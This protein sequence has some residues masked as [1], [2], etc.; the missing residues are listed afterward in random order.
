ML[1]KMTMGILGLAVAAATVL[2]TTA[3]AQTPQRTCRPAPVVV[4]ATNAA[5]TATGLTAE[6]VTTTLQGGATLAELAGSPEEIA[7]LQ[8][9]I[10]QQALIR[11]DE[12]VAKG[13][14]TA[15]RAAHLKQRL[16]KAVERLVT[17]GGGPYWGEGRGGLFWGNWRT[18][19]AAY[20]DMTTS[21]L[22]AALA[23]GESLA[24]LATAQGKSVEG[25][26]E[27]LSAKAATRLQ[28]AVAEG[29]ITQE[30]ADR[31]LARLTTVLTRMVQGEGPCSGPERRLLPLGRRLG[32][33]T[34]GNADAIL[35]LLLGE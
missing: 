28:T 12:A 3:Y 13:V 30:E 32:N 2:P 25:L 14:I 1:H 15:E 6:E 33:A 29:L 11:I 4:I 17:N 24:D 5:V 16:D 9:V 23:A 8:Q 27:V 10:S 7:A 26:V 22:A 20:L 18:E 34:D 35:N 21:E 19:A 31:L